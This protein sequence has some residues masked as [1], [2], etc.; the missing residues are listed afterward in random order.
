MTEHVRPAVA[1]DVDA[2]T[3]MA[4]DRRSRYARY[5]PVFWRPAANAAQVHR[6]YLAQLVA[7]H[8]VITLVTE[9]SGTVIGFI[10]ATLGDAPAVYSP[11]GR[12]CTIDDFVVAPGRWASTGV[13]LLR[14]A[15]K[16][17]A[18][19]GAIQAVVVTAHLDQAKREALRLCG[20]S[21][22]S[23]WW[24]TSWTPKTANA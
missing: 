21:I 7:D 12:T 14:S 10:I 1:A 22:A 17:A 23:E 8:D 20:L 24:V 16:Q 9:E 3:V 5:Q 15:I 4:T 18:G 6:P 13:Q 19:R 2:M 11:G